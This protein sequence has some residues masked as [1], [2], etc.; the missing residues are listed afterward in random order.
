M[1]VMEIFGAPMILKTGILFRVAIVDALIAT[2]LIV[3]FFV[4]LGSVWAQ[5]SGVEVVVQNHMNIFHNNDILIL[6]FSALIIVVTSVL[7]VVFGL[8]GGEE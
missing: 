2:L 4:I 3:I 6:L 7:I 8:N 5:N 1:Q